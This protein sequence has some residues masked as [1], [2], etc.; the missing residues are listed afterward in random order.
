MLG[1]FE[2]YWFFWLNIFVLGFSAVYFMIK[3][4]RNFGYV[5]LNSWHDFKDMPGWKK[6]TWQNKVRFIL[7]LKIKN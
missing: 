1:I 4:I 6:L 5:D 2:E 3:F 7:K